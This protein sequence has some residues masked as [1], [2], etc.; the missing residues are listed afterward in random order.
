MAGTF[1][2]FL[3]Q[4]KTTVTAENKAKI[5]AAQ[6][7]AAAAAKL[8]KFNSSDP[9]K[10]EKEQAAFLAAAEAASNLLGVSKRWSTGAASNAEAKK[11]FDAYT[12]AIAALKKLNPTRATAVEKSIAYVTPDTQGTLGRNYYTGKGTK[13]NPFLQSGKPFTGTYNNRKYKNSV[14]FIKKRIT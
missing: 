3:N 2:D 13:A 4:Y 5:A 1:E 14:Y 10:K 8:V 9:V 6:K 7:A 12:K 11:A